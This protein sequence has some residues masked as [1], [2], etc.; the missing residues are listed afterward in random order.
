MLKI[1]SEAIFIARESNVYRDSKNKSVMCRCTRENSESVA[2]KQLELGDRKV[3]C[4][5]NTC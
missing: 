2:T 4:G 5:L 3:A 1:I